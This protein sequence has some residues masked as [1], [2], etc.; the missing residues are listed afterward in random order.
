TGSNA[1]AAALQF[2]SRSAL[3]ACFRQRARRAR[4]SFS[5]QGSAVFRLHKRLEG[6][7]DSQRL[8]Q[9]TGPEVEGDEVQGGQGVILIPGRGVQDPFGEVVQRHELSEARSLAGQRG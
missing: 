1:S 6:P 3:A 8:I 7:Q 2:S 9:F 4:D 5:R